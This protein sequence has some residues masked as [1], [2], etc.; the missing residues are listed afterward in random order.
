MIVG[1][2]PTFTIMARR[3]TEVKCNTVMPITTGRPLARTRTREVPR[4]V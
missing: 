4:D 2:V 1:T 3:S